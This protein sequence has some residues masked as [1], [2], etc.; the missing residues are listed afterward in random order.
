MQCIR[1]SAPLHRDCNQPVYVHLVNCSSYTDQPMCTWLVAVICEATYGVSR[2]LP[3]EQREAHFLQ[4]VTDTLRG[5]GR[6]LLPVVALGRAQV[7]VCVCV[8]CKCMFV[9]ACVWKCVCVC[10]YPHVSVLVCVC[11]PTCKCV[12]AYLCV[13]VCAHVCVHVCLCAYFC[14]CMLLFACVRM[15]V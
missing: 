10:A 1:W 4:R 13:C 14:V 6:V 12:C 5:G 11:V 8:L 15:S 2:H 7:C 3:R 9:C